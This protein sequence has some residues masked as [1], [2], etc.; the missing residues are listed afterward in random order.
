MGKYSLGRV[1]INDDKNDE[2]LLIFTE[3]GIQMYSLNLILSEMDTFEEIKKIAKQAGC[4]TYEKI[5]EII[6][7]KELGLGKMEVEYDEEI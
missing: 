5:D 2:V 6:H 7:N 1:K 3:T 4:I